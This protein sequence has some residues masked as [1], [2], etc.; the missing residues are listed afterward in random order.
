MTGPPMASSQSGGTAMVVPSQ[1]SD[2]MAEHGPVIPR[3]AGDGWGLVVFAAVMMMLLGVFHA[4]TGL[5]AILK[6]QFFVFTSRNYLISVDVTAWG[7]IHLIGGVIVALAGFSVLRRAL[8]ARAIGILL[9]A[10]SA[11]ANF[12][13]I[14][15]YPFWSLLMVVLDVFV[16]W[17]LARHG[18]R[19]A[20]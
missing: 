8:W 13:F 7:W 4:L 6:D 3:E 2:P 19:V 18:R 16:I 9:A 11:I 10:L 5:T 20:A 15:Y 1:R 17:A 14:P 12:L